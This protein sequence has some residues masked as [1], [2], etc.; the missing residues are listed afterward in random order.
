DFGGGALFLLVGEI[1]GAALKL[2]VASDSAWLASG[3]P[4]PA[5]LLRHREQNR[6]PGKG[7][8]FLGGLGGAPAWIF[9]HS[10]VA[11]DRG[12]PLLSAF[13]KFSPEEWSPA[14]SLSAL[15]HLLVLGLVHH[16]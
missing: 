13:P 6:S 7:G 10:F 9:Y 4:L 11:L 3:E 2:V 12:Y 15:G 8:S 14:D 16:V 1:E 5:Q